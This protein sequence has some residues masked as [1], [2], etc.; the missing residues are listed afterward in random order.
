[1]P[2][3]RA[4]RYVSARRNLLR[5]DFMGFRFW[6]GAWCFLILVLIV[7][8]DLS[9]LVKFITRFSEE[10]FSALISL[11]FIVE[12]FKQLYDVCVNYSPDWKPFL[13]FAAAS[14]PYYCACVVGV[15]FVLL[16]L[17]TE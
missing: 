14:R 2:P 7:A 4:L 8:F 10:S 5:I 16:Y 12:A 17:C 6:L 9:F 3:P 15:S 11:I 13:S 1:M